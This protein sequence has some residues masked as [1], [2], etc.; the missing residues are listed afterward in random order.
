[1]KYKSILHTKG[2]LK[3]PSVVDK[4]AIHNIIDKYSPMI[5]K[6]AY[7]NTRDRYAS[8]DITQEVFIKLLRNE[9]PFDSEEHLKA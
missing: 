8:D 7:Q 6:I 4:Q 2:V 9:K 5:Y 3:L 1:M